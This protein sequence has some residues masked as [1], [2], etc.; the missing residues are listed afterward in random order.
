MMGFDLHGLALPPAMADLRPNPLLGDH[1][2]AWPSDQY[3]DEYAAGCAW[4]GEAGDDVRTRRLVD[5]PGRW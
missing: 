1:G 3:R 5:L 2:V 4:A